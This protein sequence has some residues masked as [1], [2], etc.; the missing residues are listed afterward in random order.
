MASQG[1][2][3]PEAQVLLTATAEANNRAAKDASISHYQ[4]YIR[5]LTHN[6][7]V[8]VKHETMVEEERRAR[9]ATLTLFDRRA[10]FGPAKEIARF[11]AELSGTLDK[12]GAEAID[13]NKKRDPMSTLGPYLLALAVM[14]FFW[15]LRMLLDTFCWADVCH[16]ASTAASTINST[17]FLGLLIV[18]WQSG[19]MTLQRINAFMDAAGAGGGFSAGSM[20]NAVAA[21]AAV[22]TQSGQG[23]QQ[24]GAGSSKVAGKAIRAPEASSDGEDD[25]GVQGAERGASYLGSEVGSGSQVRRRKVQ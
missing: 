1:A 18:G 22:Q 23:G 11:R 12:L 14:V 13:Q 9:A 10:D 7:S 4:K 19:A 2:H 5:K 24:G 6:G 15:L 16:R 8:H 25:D 3:F 20:M 21:A 17:I